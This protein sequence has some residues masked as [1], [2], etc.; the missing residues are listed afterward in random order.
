MAETLLGTAG[1]VASL[2]LGGGGAWRRWA[3]TAAAVRHI[4]CARH[5]AP[6][7]RAGS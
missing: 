7:L 5:G 2:P 1:S 4:A 6:P 3:T